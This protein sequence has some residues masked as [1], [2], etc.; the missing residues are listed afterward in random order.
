MSPMF[1]FCTIWSSCGRL[2]KGGWLKKIKE[3]TKFK[4]KGGRTFNL[5]KAQK[6]KG[7]AGIQKATIANLVFV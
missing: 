7:G 3:I 1:D 6:L 2:V 5:R 4:G